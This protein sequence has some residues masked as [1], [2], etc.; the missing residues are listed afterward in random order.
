MA[1]SARPPS[2]A[3]HLSRWRPRKARPREVAG[4]AATIVAADDKP[5]TGQ[6]SALHR[7]PPARA[8]G[9]APSRERYAWLYDDEDIWA[10]AEDD[11]APVVIQCPAE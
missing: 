6:G 10:A 5:A 1:R 8:P 7:V 9:D 4:K 3:S 11:D 2:L